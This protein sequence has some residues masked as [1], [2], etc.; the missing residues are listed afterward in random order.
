MTWDSTGEYWRGPSGAADDTP[1]GE[2]GDDR[3]RGAGDR[4]R[5][6]ATGSTRSEAADTGAAGRAG[7]RRAGADRHGD[8]ADD[9]AAAAPT[10]GWAA[11]AP[12]SGWV[13]AA[14]TT[15]AGAAAPTSGGWISEAPTSG[16]WA[17]AAP[18][19]GAGAN[20]G[21]LGDPPRASGRG[22]RRRADP[23]DDPTAVP[24][25][26]WGA[27]GVDSPSTETGRRQRD[28]VGWRE[29]A[30]DSAPGRWDGAGSRQ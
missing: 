25:S 26:G 8:E 7:R 23:D 13:G 20:S 4:R 19:T 28:T 15:G 29:P 24:P 14:P 21:L 30:D 11:A 17:A 5:G 2:S 1:G 16:G 27:G 9:W 22:R 6:D 12:T 18:T 10:S 3:W